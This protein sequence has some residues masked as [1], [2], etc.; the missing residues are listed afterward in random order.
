MI[1]NMYQKYQNN[2]RKGFKV[3]QVTRVMKLL[4]AW[5][6]STVISIFEDFVIACKI[7]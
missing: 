1:Y 3:P 2:T 4:A 7:G 5:D 6:F